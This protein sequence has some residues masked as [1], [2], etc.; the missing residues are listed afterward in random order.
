MFLVASTGFT[1]SPRALASRSRAPAVSMK[2]GEHIGERDWN[3]GPDGRASQLT[4]DHGKLV[5]TLATTGNINT[6]DNNP[7]LPCSPKEMADDMHECIKAGVSVL[8]IHARN[9]LLKPTMRLDKFRETVRLIK[10]RDPDV[11]IQ[12]STGGRAPPVQFEGVDVGD[13][14]MDPLNLMPEMASYT[15]GSVNLGAIVYQNDA[16]LVKDM[17]QRFTA[18]GIK[19]QVEA[20]DS[21][22]ISNANLLV[23]QGL[24]QRPLDFGFVMGAPGAQECSLRQLGHLVS[25]LEPG[26]TWTSIGVGKFEMPLAYMAIAMGGHVR[27]GL[28]DNNKSPDGKVATNYDLVKHVVDAAR[29]MGREVATPE[30]ARQ[31]LSMPAANADWILAKLD[32]SVPLES[33]VSNMAPYQNLEPIPGSLEMRPMAGHPDC[34]KGLSL[35]PYDNPSIPQ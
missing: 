5:I 26:D 19:P 14:R 2:W 21:N 22:M 25:M 15:P 16:K 10:E 4:R 8:H 28:E 33:L 34:P 35:L 12:I 30:E 9:E 13:W 11:I 3:H 17:A 7:S 20:F 18:T 27:V 29:A 23:K 24:L 1:A 31:I 6:R 32:P